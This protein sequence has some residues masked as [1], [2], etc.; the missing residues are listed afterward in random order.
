MILIKNIPSLQHLLSSY[1]T[2]G[3]SI[4]FVPT[5]GAL[6]EGH[7]SLINES[8]EN[9]D[10]TVC[11]IFINPVQF[12]DMVDFKKYPRTPEKDILML[13]QAN[14]DVLFFPSV[15][16]IYPKGTENES[17]YDLGEI[18]HL[19]EGKFRPGHFQGVCRVI[20]QLI[21]I[22]EPD[23]LYLGQKDYQQ[24][25]VI[26]KFLK[27]YPV[28][29][30]VCA[31]KR[32]ENGLALSSRNMRLSDSD[33]IN[34]AAL[35]KSLQYIADNYKETDMDEL[36]KNAKTIIESNGFSSIDYVEIC[37]K[38]TLQ[39]VRGSN[40]SAKAVALAAAHLNGV[41]LIDNMLI[42]QA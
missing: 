28:E 38:E 33:K 2:Q 6:H 27:E 31:T 32:E 15:S 16:D 7:L 24:C 8:K 21:N 18:E 29:V 30:S 11:S 5:M 39:P 12:N 4:G 17:A 26:K 42:D 41:R 19:L 35:F 1:K 25:L 34:A 37:D 22:V 14:T 10:I 40:Y 13:E 3:K 36:I 20:Q 23:T 9:S